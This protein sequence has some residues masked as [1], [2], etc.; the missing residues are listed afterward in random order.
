MFGVHRGGLGIWTASQY[1][2][3]ETRPQTYWEARLFIRS[4][5]KSSTSLRSQREGCL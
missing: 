2:Y 5:N 3:Q 1:I 4:L